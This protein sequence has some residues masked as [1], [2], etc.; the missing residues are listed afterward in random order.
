MAMSRNPLEYHALG[1][2]PFRIPS[3]GKYTIAKVKPSQ[4]PPN[5]HCNERQD[6][7]STRHTFLSSNNPKKLKKKMTEKIKNYLNLASI[8][9]QFLYNFLIIPSSKTIPHKAILWVEI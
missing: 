6:L 8:F 4:G 3:S 1:G 2:Q 5:L 9:L 7:Y